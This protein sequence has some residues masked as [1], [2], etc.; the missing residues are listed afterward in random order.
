MTNLPFSAIVCGSKTIAGKEKIVRERE[1]ELRRRRKRREET[2]RA[3]RKQS[4]VAAVEKT[5]K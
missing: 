2:L 1:R 4:K 5:G 3:R